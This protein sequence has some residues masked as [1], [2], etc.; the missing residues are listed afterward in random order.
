MSVKHASKKGEALVAVMN[1]LDAWR[2]VREKSWYRVPV[3]NAPRNWPPK[4]LAFYQTKVFGEEAFAVR[5]FGRVVEIREVERRE[6]FPD[7]PAN[8]KS[9]RRYFQIFIDQLEELPEPVANLL[10][11]QHRAFITTTM[12]QLET[13]REMNDLYGES[14]L[15]EAMWSELKRLKIPAEREY[16]IVYKD[17]WYF[18]DFAVFCKQ[19]KVDIETD[20]DTWHRVESQIESDNRRNNAMAALGWKVLRFNGN[21]IREQMDSYC[22]REVVATTN[23]LG[24]PKSLSA[25]SI[26]TTSDGPGSQESLFE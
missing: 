26:N 21:Q 19:A 6:L 23:R 4:Y 12:Y 20:G 14:P 5:Y 1:D 17:E 3:Q 16:P 8:A 7:E 2:I 10:R 25:P 24:G 11:R 22:V 13:A 15:E 18:L 9:A